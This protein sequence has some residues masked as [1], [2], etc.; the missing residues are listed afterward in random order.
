[1]SVQADRWAEWK[2]GYRDGLTAGV[3]VAEACAAEPGATAL[4]VLTLL[5]ALS[6]SSVIDTGHG[7]AMVVVTRLH[8]PD[9]SNEPP[10][11]T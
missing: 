4:D 3:K 11:N 2:D 10:A 1:M 8:P 9:V 7:D 5:S 6:D